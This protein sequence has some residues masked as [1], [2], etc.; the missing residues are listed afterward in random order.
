MLDAAEV[1]PAVDDDSESGESVPKE[2]FRY[3]YMFVLKYLCCD[4][5]RGLHFCEL[6]VQTDMF[7]YIP[8]FIV[9]VWYCMQYK[10][11]FE[12]EPY[13]N[14]NTCPLCFV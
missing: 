6:N 1:P 7:L 4:C 2:W 13:I 12:V 8:L 14:S 11:V 5:Y 3:V 10:C 9:N